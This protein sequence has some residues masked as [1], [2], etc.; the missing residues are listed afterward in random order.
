MAIE[1]VQTKTLRVLPDERGRLMEILRCDDP[2]F[3][4][5]GQAYMTSVYP[6]VVKAW[7]YHKAQYDNLA[8]VKGMVK[9]VL[10]DD[11]AGSSTRGELQEFFIGD[12]NP[13]LVQVP[14]NVYHGFKNI[15]AEEALVINCATEPYNRSQPDEYRLDPHTPQIP[16]DWARKD[17]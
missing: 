3:R 7:H 8:V 5:F 4:R 13:L 14:P 10:Y 9:L 2:I 16:Y 12:H 17:R 6:G 11:R 15:G 1:G